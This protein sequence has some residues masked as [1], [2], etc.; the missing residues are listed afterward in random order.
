MAFSEFLGHVGETVQLKGFTGF[1]AGLDIKDNNTG[2]TS[3]FTKFA[4]YQIMYHVSTM[5]PFDPNNKQQVGFICFFLVS[6]SC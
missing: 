3:V 2:T 6:F 1:R 4:E 5:L